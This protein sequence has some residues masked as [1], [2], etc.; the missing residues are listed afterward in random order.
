MKIT[1]LGFGVHGISGDVTT[2]KKW[3]IKWK[4]S[5]NVTWRLLFRLSVLLNSRVNVV[6]T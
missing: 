1:G 5:F 3:K 2:P 4:R 6:S